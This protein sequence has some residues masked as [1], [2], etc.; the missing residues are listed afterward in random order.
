MPPRRIRVA[1]Q[2]DAPP[3]RKGD[4]A[5]GAALSAEDA[6]LLGAV[7]SPAYLRADTLAA[8]R[9]RVVEDNAVSLSRVLRP[10]VYAAVHAELAARR[11]RDWQTRGPPSRRRYA[12]LGAGEE[13][14]G[15]LTLCAL[16]DM[17]ASPAFARWLRALTGVPLG[18][19]DEC[20]WRKWRRGDYTLAQDCEE[21]DAASTAADGAVNV[22]VVLSV[23]RDEDAD[24]WEDTRVG[25][26]LVYLARGE[27]AEFFTQPCAGN[28]LTV[29]LRRERTLRFVKYVTTRRP[30][31]GASTWPPPTTARDAARTLLAL[32]L[33]TILQHVRSAAPKRI[34][35]GIS[36]PLTG[37]RRASGKRA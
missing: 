7:L 8:L 32:P 11:M 3:K 14:L 37:S 23:Q 10:E 34:K 36:R 28:A 4:K 5:A 20:S 35:R 19:L 22:D 2:G 21:R 29:A 1:L 30:R 13:A 6:A 24:A 18:E 9:A 31:T 33:F 16:R 15:C 26:Y 25:G 12:V 27:D 17:L